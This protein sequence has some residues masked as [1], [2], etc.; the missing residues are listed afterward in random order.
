MNKIP[1]L[2]AL[3][4]FA[5]G[6]CEEGPATYT[7]DFKIHEPTDGATF[8]D[9]ESVHM[10]VDFEAEATIH[11]AKVTVTREHDGEAVYSWE[12]HVHAEG[13]HSHHADFTL[14]TTEHSDFTLEA[15]SWDHGGSEADAVSMTRHFHGIP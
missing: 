10:H 2:L 11:M 7:V 6:S 14:E 15:K 4:A 13:M 3:A 8:A 12:E 9:G 1:P 5:F